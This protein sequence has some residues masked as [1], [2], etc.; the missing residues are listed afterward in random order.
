MARPKYDI[1]WGK[2]DNFLKAQCDGVGIAGLLGMHP[3]TFY[4][5]CEEKYNISFS[6]YAALKRSEGKELLRA[7][8]FQQAMEGDRTMQIWLSKQYL[9]M[10]EHTNI[11]QTIESLPEIILLP[12][13]NAKPAVY[14]EADVTDIA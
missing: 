11:H 13:N 7:K 10:R 12:P 8:M 1:D 14:D 2:V 6:E 3:N 9:E 5:L 4:R